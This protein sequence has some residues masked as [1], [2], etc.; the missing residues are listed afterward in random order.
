MELTDKFEFDN[1]DNKVKYSIKH[2][3]IPIKLSDELRDSIYYLL[4]YVPNIKSEQSRENDLLLNPRYDDFIFIEIM[5]AMNLRDE[6]V[7]F[8][9]E[10]S[11]DLIKPFLNEICSECPKLIMTIANEETKTMSVL[12][13][14]RNAVAHGNFNVVDNSTVIG[15]DIQKYEHTTEYKGFF[16]IDPSNLLDALRKIQFDYNSQELIKRAFEKNGY[17]VDSYQEKYQRSH[18]FEL[19]A[20]K[21]DKKYAIDIKN[22]NY[23]KEVDKDF[24]QE[25]LDQYTDLTQDITPL[26]IINT[27]YLD[28]QS[29]KELLKHKV[30]ILDVKNVK[31]M[32]AGRDMVSEIE[33]AQELKT[34]E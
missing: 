18:K 19:F 28:E 4:W 11:E 2:K 14:I 10:I 25:L 24:I 22:Y 30:I 21:N 33:K 31:K 8:T 26:L 16:K 6:D 34:K 13:H 29:K 7:L 32:I 9:D 1:C 12:R 23:Q 27:S 3:D 15:F 20:S 17:F 5:K